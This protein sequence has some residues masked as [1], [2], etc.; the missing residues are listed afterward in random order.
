MIKC[1]DQIIRVRTQ[2]YNFLTPAEIEAFI[3]FVKSIDMDDTWFHF[4][5]VGG[6]GR[7]GAFM[8]LYDKMKNPQVSDK[9]IMYRHARMGASYPIYT[10]AGA[11]ARMYAEKAAIAL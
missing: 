4:H 5:C 2:S 8:M 6:K 9:D 11:N 1:Y 3:D 10:G 7:T